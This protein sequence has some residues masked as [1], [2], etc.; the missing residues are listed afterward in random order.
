VTPVPCSTAAHTGTG[1][2]VAWLFPGLI[3]L[4]ARQG[5]WRSVLEMGALLLVVAA[6]TWLLPGR[7]MVLSGAIANSPGRQRRDKGRGQVYFE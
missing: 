3:F 2:S 5:L 6:L 7:R 1:G 4:G